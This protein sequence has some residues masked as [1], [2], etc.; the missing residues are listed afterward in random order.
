MIRWIHPVKGVLSPAEFIPLFEKNGFIK[1]LDFFVFE[2]VCILLKKWIDKDEKIHPIS[3]NM[4]R[5]HFIN[6]KFLES[7][8]RIKD[9][10]N[11]PVEYLEIELTETMVFSDIQAFSKIIKMIH[12]AGFRCSMDDFGSG[13]SSLNM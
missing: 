6:E 8:I 3:V 4:S 5:A 10:Y 7:Y 1:D 11:I 2:E 13:Y 12:E 9:K